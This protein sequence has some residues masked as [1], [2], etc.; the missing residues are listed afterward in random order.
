MPG[1]S[2]NRVVM[3][4][5]LTRDPELRSLQS[6]TSVC[7]LGL[8]VNERFKDG[9]GEWQDRA[10]FFDWTVWGGMGEWVANNL[11]K[12]DG[13]TLE[14]RARWRQWENDQGDKR[15]AVEFTA[16][17]IVPQRKGGGGQT[18]RDKRME[19]ETNYGG[20]F[21]PHKQSDLPDPAPQEFK[22]PD[23]VAAGTAD[24]DIPF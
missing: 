22:H 11:A 23:P 3:S 9:Y 8:A 5:N 1:F 13:V 16:D 17:S 7:N 12:G 24:D 18:A 6:G 2:I 20:G 19:E 21:T 14:G 4:G 15:S 10:N